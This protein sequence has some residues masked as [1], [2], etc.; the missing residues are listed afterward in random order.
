MP[1]MLNRHR[2]SLGVKALSQELD[3]AVRRTIE[4]LQANAARVSI[5]RAQVVAPHLQAEVVIENLAGHK[6]PTAYPSRR[7]WI[8]FT[9]RDRHGQLVFESGG[10]Q[11]TGAIGG[12][13]N[14]TDPGRYEPHYTEI[15]QRDQVQV[16]EAIMAGPEGEVTTGLLT[17]VRFIK[18]NRLLPRGFNKATAEED[19]AVQGRAAQDAD[20]LG[21]HDRIRYVVEVADAEGPF[22]VQAE[23]WYQ[24]IAYR[25]A[26]NLAPYNTPETNRLVEFYEAMSDVSGVILAT[27]AATAQ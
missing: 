23:L 3:T 9:V 8:H 10:L 18:D 14:D 12:N 11:A 13:D 25:W 26:Q 17:A 2:A 4:H 24:P 5:E 22:Q 21:G 19:V 27:G 6:L 15:T 20:Y 16:Y 7:A 1:R